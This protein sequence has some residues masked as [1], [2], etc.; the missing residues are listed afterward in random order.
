MVLCENMSTGLPHK[1]E[2]LQLKLAGLPHKSGD[3]QPEAS[4][5]QEREDLQPFMLFR[6]SKNQIN[7]V[8][9]RICYNYAWD[10]GLNY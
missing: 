3:L 8:I 2:G 7:M 6:Y 1:L 4:L 10:L 5:R 9:L